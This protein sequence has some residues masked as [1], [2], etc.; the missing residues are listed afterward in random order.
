MNSTGAFHKK[1]TLFTKSTGAF[2]KK[3]TLFIIR[4]MSFRVI[5]KYR[6]FDIRKTKNKGYLFLMCCLT[7]LTTLVWLI[8]RV[9][10]RVIVFKYGNKMHQI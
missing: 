3:H 9:L 10:I 1:H 7:C 4:F 5:T 2:H 6:S 8:N